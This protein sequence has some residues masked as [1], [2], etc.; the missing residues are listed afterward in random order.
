[1]E[2][3]LQKII[4]HWGIA[5]RRQAEQMIQAG[6]IRVNGI[7]AVTGQKANPSQDCIEVDGQPIRASHRPKPVYLLLNKPSG[8][9]STC[10]DPK[11]RL[12]VMD[13]LPRSLQKGQGIHPVGRLDAESTGALLLTNDGELTFHLTH[14]RHHIPK[15]YHVW[16]EGYPPKTTLQIWRQGVILSGRK[17]LPAV[18]RQIGTSSPGQTQL[19]VILFEGRN[20]QIRR[21]AEQLGYPVKKLH[22]V[23]IGSVQLN[24]KNQ[25]LLSQGKYRFLTETEIR[26]LKH[27][28]QPTLT[29]H[30]GTAVT[31][32]MCHH[33]LC[34]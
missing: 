18:I 30:Q 17:T 2:D 22:R 24:P 25:P 26:C 34:E 9:V 11:G 29:N 7:T 20:R 10:N 19:E 21:V 32:S 3:R 23:A 31:R 5:S 8:I 33:P 27:E 1:M 28:S 4:A 6:R 16:V 12:K 13:L 15:T 14:P